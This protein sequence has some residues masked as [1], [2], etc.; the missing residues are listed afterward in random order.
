M[1]LMGTT[2]VGLGGS[3]VWR[4]RANCPSGGGH[5][6]PAESEV[7]LGHLTPMELQVGAGHVTPAM[8]ELGDGSRDCR[9]TGSGGWDT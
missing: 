9:Q 7:W 3:R 2:C 8:P 5:V 6:T 1:S 4:R